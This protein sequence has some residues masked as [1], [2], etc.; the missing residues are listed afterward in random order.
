MIDNRLE[1]QQEILVPM[2]SAYLPPLPA[3]SLDARKTALEV[4]YLALRDFDGDTLKKAWEATITAHTGRAWPVAGVIAGHARHARKDR[5]DAMIK[6]NKNHDTQAER[7]MYWQRV[8]HSPKALEAVAL[9]VAWSLKLAVLFENQPIS[10]VSLPALVEAKDRARR[11]AERFQ[12]GQSLT[13]WRDSRDMGA[14]TPAVADA[15]LRL[16]RGL[17]LQEAETEAEILATNEKQGD[18]DVQT[19]P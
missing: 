17:L 12:S 3:M 7:E 8:K 19:T 1:V 10:T 15:A 14:P 13:H 16:W 2:Q 5:R 18:Q 11:T 6:E 4:Y 9:G